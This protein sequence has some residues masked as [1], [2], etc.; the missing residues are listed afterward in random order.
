MGGTSLTIGKGVEI[1]LDTAPTPFPM[2]RACHPVSQMS[3]L[4]LTRKLAVNSAS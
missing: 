4:W 1:R 2:V 3:T